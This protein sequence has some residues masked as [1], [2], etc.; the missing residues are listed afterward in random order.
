[1]N[2]F[3]FSLLT[4]TN[5]QL[6]LLLLFAPSRQKSSPSAQWIR[7]EEGGVGRGAGMCSLI[8]FSISFSLVF[9]SGSTTREGK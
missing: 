4:G 9:V 8:S 3:I 6:L 7:I 5:R 1:M 2:N